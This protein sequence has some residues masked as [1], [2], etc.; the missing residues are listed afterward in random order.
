MYSIKEV[1]K[2]VNI[3]ANAIR[4]YEKKKLIHPERGENDYRYFKAEDIAKLQMIILYRKMGFTIEAI[5]D[6][7]HHASAQT[8]VEQFSAQYKLLNTHIDT[9]KRV[10]DTMSVSIEQMLNENATEADI[11]T[12]MQDTTKVIKKC[13]EW[14]DLWAFDQW[15][16]KYDK[17]IKTPGKGLNFYKNYEEVLN[18]TAE[19]VLEGTVVEIGIGTGNLAEKIMQKI[20]NVNRY[21]GIDQS[22]EMLKLAKE[23]CPQVQLRIGNFLK[24]PLDDAC[25]DTV[26]TSYAFHHCDS[27]ERV[28]AIGE[29]DRILKRNGRIIITDLMF[30]TVSD[31]AH[32]EAHAS[33]AE[34]DDL[35]DEF[36][37]TVE[38]LRHIFAGL[39]YSIKSEAIDDL[40][41]VLTAKKQSKPT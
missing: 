37:T 24:L 5:F 14:K 22:I 21:I 2:I 4:F 25:A 27:E 29:M 12:T 17:D 8:M 6:L 30:D 16:K 20:P 19:N 18:R 15:A 35:E 13:N 40:I 9:M 11:I 23:K 33:Q 39:G 7:I 10:R 28:I 26:V 31:R 38:E 34:K 36:F 3:N 41:W 32:F 1:S